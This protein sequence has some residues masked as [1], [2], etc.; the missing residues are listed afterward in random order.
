MAEILFISSDNLIVADNVRNLATGSNINNAV[1]TVTVSAVNG[2]TVSGQS[3]PLTLSFVTGSSGK[4][5]GTLT[6]T[7]IVTENTKYW[8]TLV[9]SAGGGL[10]LTTT[11]PM[12]VRDFR[13]D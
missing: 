3:W 4:Y 6:D 13:T 8:G 2:A 11:V 7:M 5:R 9:I 12:I 1:V 10:K